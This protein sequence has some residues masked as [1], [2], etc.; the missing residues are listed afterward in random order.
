LDARREASASR[1][2]ALLD[3][4]DVAAMLGMKKSWVYARSRANEIPTVKLGPRYYRYRRE[5]I[6]DWISEQE[7]GAPRR[8]NDVVPSRHAE[9]PRL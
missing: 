3:A 5:A 4:E 6:E 8:P 7:V 9:A 2:E 1:T